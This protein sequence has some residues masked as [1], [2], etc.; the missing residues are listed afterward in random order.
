MISNNMENFSKTELDNEK[1]KPIFGYDGMYQVSDLGRVRSKHSG[2]WKM[3][4]PRNDGR[5]YLQIGLYI[6]RKVKNHRVHRLVAQAFIENDD[7]TK[8]QI[9]HRN[10]CKSDN[11]LWN[12]EY[13]TAKYN[14]RYNDL[15]LRKKNGKRRKI[16]KLYNPEL[17]ISENLELFKKQ[18][19]ECCKETVQNLRKDLGL[20]G[21]RPKYVYNKIKKL[22]NQD[23]T[24]KQNL[25]LFRL[26]G[27]E[28]SRETVR[29]LR[30]DLGLK[31]SRPQ[32]VLK[33]IKDLYLP[34]LSY[35]ENIKLFRANGIEC[36]KATLYKLR[37]ELGLIKK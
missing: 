22:F 17:T 34:D 4:K 7:E 23:L 32:Y 33:E 37:K 27:I 5:G 11:R 9:N 1:W 14:L 29:Q 31:T 21:S 2:E 8:T 12:L 35:Q 13:C 28:C 15:N 24:N 18:G 3:M 25:E 26:N 16:E 6:D 19:I 36:S 20:K 10:E 30:K